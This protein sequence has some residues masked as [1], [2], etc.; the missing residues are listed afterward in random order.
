MSVVPLWIVYELGLEKVEGL[1]LYKYI[2]QQDTLVTFSRGWF[3][4]T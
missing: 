3:E 1:S 2:T 4:S